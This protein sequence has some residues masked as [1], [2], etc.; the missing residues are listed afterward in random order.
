ML[1]KFIIE[2]YLGMDRVKSA[3]FETVIHETIS[4]YLWYFQIYEDFKINLPNIKFV[5]TSIE[6]K[7]SKREV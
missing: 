6:E 5:K 3:R 1:L 7:S 4:K 2:P